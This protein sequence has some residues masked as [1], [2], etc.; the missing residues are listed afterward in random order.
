MG[1]GAHCN[2]SCSLREWTKW[3]GIYGLQQGKF[4]IVEEVPHS[5]NFLRGPGSQERHI[6]AQF[7][8]RII[9]Q[10]G[11][12]REMGSIR[13]EVLDMFVKVKTATSVSPWRGM[14]VVCLGLLI[15]PEQGR[16]R[17]LSHVSLESY[18]AFILPITEPV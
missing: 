3:V 16:Q 12:N 17:R 5:R 4:A 7:K 18:P 10:C 6:S 15:S 13:E 11:Y 9:F 14:Y 8:F 2:N 1:Q